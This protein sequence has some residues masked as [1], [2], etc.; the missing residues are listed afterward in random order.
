M[1][2]LFTLLTLFAC[3]AGFA[4]QD[5]QFNMYQFNPLIINPA[6]AGA[7]DGLTTAMS[8]RQQWVGFDGAPRTVALSA[9]MPVMDKK[10]GVG[11]TIT[12][13][14]M[15]ARN[16]IAAYGNVAYILK[17]DRK[18]KLHFG[19]NAGY[20][21]YQFNFGDIKFGSTEV[22]S[23]SV[24]GANQNFSAL[25]LNAGVYYRMGTFF[26]GISATHLN[27]A[28]VYELQSTATTTGSATYSYKLK[29]HLIFTIGKSF[30]LDKNTIFAPTALVKQV[31][32]KVGA[33][34]NLN[35]FLYKK[36]WL[37]A[38][39]RAGYGPGGLI[40][41]YVN[42]NLR[43]GYSFDSG[44]SDARRLGGSHEVMVGYDFIKTT[45]RA[46]MIN[47]RFL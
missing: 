8:A 5:P 40:Q 1:K 37:G 44:L 35:F 19:L 12:N 18:S 30:I 4:Q 22:Q 26:A 25:D 10:L 11:L 43:V 42:Y 2:Y 27:S 28:K 6:Y 23:T 24:L 45:Y 16:V 47:P 14:K 32:N 20:N 34:I 29:T 3:L 7:R 38:F 21:R 46:R 15:G 17:I 36:V 41:Y 31:N 13:D 33:D 39:Y 9:H